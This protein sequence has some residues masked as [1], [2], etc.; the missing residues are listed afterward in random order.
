MNTIAAFTGPLMPDL[1]DRDNPGVIKAE[2]CLPLST[3][4]EPFRSHVPD[5]DALLAACVGAASVQDY[6]LNTF[7]YAGTATNIYR[8]SGSSWTSVGSGYTGQTWEFVAFNDK[9]YAVNG[10]DDIQVDDIGSSSFLAV[11]DAPPNAKHIG[12]SRNFV[13]VGNLVSNPR[14]VQW[15]AVGDGDVWTPDGTNQAGSQV[16]RDGGA[17]TQIVGGEYATVFVEHGIYV[18]RLSLIHI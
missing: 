17:V 10:I 7:S 9:V 14:T 6:S 1:P 16:V 2:N 4:F 13:I 5:M 8:R 15:S 18:M 3:S 11:A 12:V